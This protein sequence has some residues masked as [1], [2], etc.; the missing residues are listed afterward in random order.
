MKVLPRRKVLVAL[1]LVICL[2]VF[3]A[4][5]E[6]YTKA[7]GGGWLAS[8]SLVEGERATFGFNLQIDPD[9]AQAKGHFQLVDHGTGQKF[10]ASFRGT[11]DENFA[12]KTNDGLDV[13]LQVW[14][15]NGEDW[16]HVTVY[17]GSTLVYDNE[18]AVQGG[19][20]SFK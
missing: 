2:I 10:S 7:S 16:L 11:A 1:V 4:G 3:A 19:N 6:I 9:T 18:A 17:D 8:A 5:C 20:I 13:Y 14:Q 12:G 15:S